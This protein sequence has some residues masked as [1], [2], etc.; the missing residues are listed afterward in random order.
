MIEYTT[1][2]L[3][4]LSC[5]AAALLITSVAG[6]SFVQATASTPA[7]QAPALRTVTSIA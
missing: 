4:H 7:T 5:V 6:A 1:T 3:Q 2:A